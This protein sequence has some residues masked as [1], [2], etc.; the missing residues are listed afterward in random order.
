MRMREEDWDRVM[1]INL[2][3]VSLH[4]GSL[5]DNDEKAK[6]KI[7]N[8]SSVIGIAGMQDNQITLQP[9]QE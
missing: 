2:K 6:W 1:D 4:Q 3:G 8:I 5:Q 9:R 7:I